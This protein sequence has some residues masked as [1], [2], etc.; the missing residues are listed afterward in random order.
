MPAAKASIRPG[1]GTTFKA[2]ASPVS[3]DRVD[4]RGRGIAW[5]KLPL[6]RS[7]IVLFRLDGVRAMVLL[8]K[9]LLFTVMAPGT[10]AI[11]VPWLITSRLPASSG[12]A[13]CFALILFAAGGAIYT[14]CVWDFAVFGRGTPA[15]IDAPKK[16]VVRGL[17]RFTRNPMYLG[18]LTVI[19]AWAMLFQAPALAA[20][21]I[22]VAIVFHL[23]IVLYEEPHLERE[24][25][26]DYAAYKSE[27]GRWLPR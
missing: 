20:Y 25:G 18:V 14:W 9:N 8:L 24:F 27:V 23:F 7:G 5:G 19:S 15:P 6:Y 16:L 26:S 22:F 1:S 2:S 17:Y 4:R 12:P 10:V 21:A 3:E 11:L 13:L